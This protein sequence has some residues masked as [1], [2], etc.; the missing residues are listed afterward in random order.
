MG[1]QA[2]SAIYYDTGRLRTIYQFGGNCDAYMWGSKVVTWGTVA[3]TT[4]TW[5]VGDTCWNTAP[6]AS[7]TPGWVCT[8]AGSPGTWTAMTV[9]AH[10]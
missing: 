8:T 7:T 6:T 9:L 10:A 1:L 2:R 4:G 5:A 3:P